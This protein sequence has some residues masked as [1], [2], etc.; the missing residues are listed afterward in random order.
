[1][2]RK[3]YR[4]VCMMLVLI[5]LASCGL[6]PEE[7]AAPPPIIPRVEVAHRTIIV[8]RG[9]IVDYERFV[10]S[11]MPVR[12]QNVY[13]DVPSAVLIEHSI[14]PEVILEVRRGSR[15]IGQFGIRVW[16]G[17]VLAVFANE[18]IEEGIE[19]LQRAV[20]MAYINYN[21]A[22]RAWA[23]ANSHY[24]QLL[25]RADRERENARDILDVARA[26]ARLAVDTANAHYADVAERTDWERQNAAEVLE[27]ARVR[28][29]LGLDP[30]NVFRTAESAYENTMRLLEANLRAAR[31]SVESARRQ[32]ELSIRQAEMTYDNTI[33]NLEQNLRTARASA[34]NDDAIRRERVN[35][36]AARENL[37]DLAD[38]IDSFT[39][40]APVDGVITFFQNLYLGTTYTDAAPM[41]TISDVSA[42]FVTMNLPA[43]MV[44]LGHPFTP[45]TPVMLSASAVVDGERE[46]VEFSGNVISITV[47]QRREAQLHQDTVIIDVPDWPELVG[48]GTMVTVRMMQAAAHD[49]V[50]VPLS[51]L[52]QTGNYTFVRVVENGVARERPVEL[53]ITTRMEAEIISGLEAGEEIIV[54]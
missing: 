41:F 22:V 36:A 5:L 49:V 32:Y 18:D 31:D 27:L 51:A 14:D 37:G 35:L 24:A 3:L 54:R 26:G 45:G 48:L 29:Q 40:R 13:L 38:R 6:F 46:A 10:G 1:M 42:F 50:L 53:G 47:D 43:A 33:W 16:A 21:A 25:A 30:A 52:N 17:D 23:N 19:D 28:H 15:D 12:Q 20:D 34:D 9:D 7:A 39:M 44:T 8:G 4:A 2:A 11:V